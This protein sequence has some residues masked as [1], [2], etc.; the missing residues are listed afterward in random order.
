[1][2]MIRATETLF[3]GTS[4]SEDVAREPSRLGYEKYLVMPE[5]FREKASPR[6]LVESIILD[7]R[8][9]TSDTDSGNQDMI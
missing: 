4:D 6:V 8:L 5:N 2:L 1:M 7:V 9:S 3:C